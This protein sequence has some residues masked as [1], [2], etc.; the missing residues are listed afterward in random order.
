[1]RPLHGDDAWVGRQCQRPAGPQNTFSASNN[2]MSFFLADETSLDSYLEQP[3]VPIRF[4][5]PRKVPDPSR[6]DNRNH[7][8]DDVVSGSPSSGASVFSQSSGS[9]PSQA[10]LPIS[11]PITPTMLGPPCTGSASSSPSSGRY[12][13]TGSLSDQAVSYDEEFAGDPTSLLDSGGSAPQLIM[14][15][16]KMPSRRPF[17]GTGRNLGRLKIL[18][19]GD[20]GVGK[21]SLLKAIVQTCDHIVHVDPF[22]PLT[23][24]SKSVS[25]LNIMTTSSR[26]DSTSTTAISEVH[27][28][29]KPY[30]E[31]WSE[32]DTPRASH[33]RKSLGDV[34]LERNICFVD[35]P[36]Y[37]LESSIMETIMPCVDYVESCLNKVLS[38]TLSDSDVISMLG[39]D[40]GCQV[41]VVLYLILHRMKPADL[42]YIRR[43]ARLTN[44]IPILAQA[45]LL[46]EEQ[47]ASCKQE[48]TEQLQSAEIQPFTFTPAAVQEERVTFA[49]TI[50]YTASS[51]TV[52][53]HEV[54]D[55]S[56][57]MSPD[58]VQPLIPTELAFLVQRIFSLDGA[59][60]LRHSSAKKYL[61]WRDARPSQPRY[62]YR[63]L[64]L[65]G[66][67]YATAL[68]H[69]SMALAKVSRLQQDSDPA[70]IRMTD[71]A[72]NLQRSLAG[73]R[74]QYEALS[75][76][77]RA[78]WLTKKLHGCA[79]DGTL[80][81]MNETREMS[82]VERRRSRR[83]GASR[84]QQYRDPLGLLQVTA[85]LKVRG[86]IALEVLGSLG[87]LGGLAIWITR[88]AWPT[89]AVEL[90]NE[91]TKFWG[92]DIL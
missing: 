56:L 86:W 55:A 87:L 58:Y 45:D 78:Y 82:V 36:G 67:T 9:L 29:T 14:P 37:S 50:P 65:P 74:A 22:S 75:R 6:K 19:A 8:G 64:A 38:D 90:V 35:T 52:S 51:A 72:A 70:Q 25:Q 79:Q 77:E 84:T 20:S 92:L 41:D 31:W 48:I 66:Q 61:Q 32:L 60:W 27:A 10:Q 46:S 30:P 49:P 15:S 47:V 73:E 43:L 57:L 63:P 21:T 24:S 85:D 54:M 91:W 16:I 39:G 68:T 33:R 13:L 17:T 81:A 40:G 7:V 69:P 80:V 42:E 4:R 5:D 89:E 71:W 1:M 83:S 2:H 53:D 28:S 12:S 34:V 26:R 18:L 23:E 88:H 44:V 76:G 11:R 3:A 62:L 59:S